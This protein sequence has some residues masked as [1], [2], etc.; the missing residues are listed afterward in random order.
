MESLV[1]SVLT[2]ARFLS[3]FVITSSTKEFHSPQLEQRPTHFGDCAPQ[4]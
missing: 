1:D 3:F 2:E 4:F